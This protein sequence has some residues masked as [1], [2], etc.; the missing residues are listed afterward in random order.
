MLLVALGLL[1]GVDRVLLAHV[2]GSGGLAAT[3]ADTGAPAGT[4]S[5]LSGCAVCQA[6]AALDAAAPAA[7]AARSALP[8]AAAPPAPVETPLLRRCARVHAPRGPP[9]LRIV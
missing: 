4:D 2:H 6:R 8:I 9:L 7:H 1:P 3:A 5:P